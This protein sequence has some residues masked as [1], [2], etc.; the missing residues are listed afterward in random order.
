MIIKLYKNQKITRDKLFVLEQEQGFALFSFEE[1][2]V[3]NLDICIHKATGD[4][5]WTKFG[6]IIPSRHLTTREKDLDELIINWKNNYN[7]TY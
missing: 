6:D 2:N 4:L 7:G 1:D 5:Y 3:S